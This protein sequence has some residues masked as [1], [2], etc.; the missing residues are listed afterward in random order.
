MDIIEYNYFCS[1]K[2]FSNLSSCIC[3]IYNL[4]MNHD[5][6][7]EPNDSE[8]PEELEVEVEEPEEPESEPEKP[9]DG[10]EHYI[11]RCSLIAPCCDKAYVCRHCHNDAEDHDIDRHA[12]KEVVCAVCDH[13]QPVSQTCCNEACGITF[14]AYFCAVCNFFDDRI[15]RNYY[16]CDKCGICRVKL[17]ENDYMHCDTCGTCVS[18]NHR[19]KVDQFHTDCPICLEN[20]F[21]ST[22][23]AHVPA[24]G[25][26]I[27]SY[28][29]FQCM[30]QNRIKYNSYMDTLISS[31]PIQEEIAFVIRCNDCDFNDEVKYHP[32]GMKCGGCGGYN[33]AR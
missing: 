13:R 3:I 27:H 18:V 24:C 5:D 6:D 4:Q 22:K 1:E 11:R 2:V 16:H 28:C 33:T 17:G 30:Q 31:A 12:V 25:H 7:D 15:E 10:C 9:K 29:M 19:C 20:L 8:Q 21:H 32:Y 23:P 26:P 14:A